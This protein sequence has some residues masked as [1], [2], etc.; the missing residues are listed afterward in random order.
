MLGSDEAS[1]TG[2]VRMGLAM[3]QVDVERFDRALTT[4]L[5]PTL[6]VEGRQPLV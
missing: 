1:Y 3:R 4:I 5:S 6:S 2:G